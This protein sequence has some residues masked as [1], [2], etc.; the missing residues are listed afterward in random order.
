MAE[1]WATIAGLAITA[2][3]TAYSINAQNNAIDAANSA[4]PRPF[5][6]I[7]IGKT[8]ELAKAADVAGYQASD[9]EWLTRYQNSHLLKA[10]RDYNVSDASSNL[11]GATSPVVTNAM[12]KAGLAGDLGSNEFQKAQALGKPILSIEQRDRNFFRQLLA[13]NPQRSAGLT[14]GDVTK[15]A[16]QNTGA[17]GAYNSNIFGNKINQYNAQ[18][19]QGIQNQNA[20]VG[21]LASLAGLFSQNNRPN[22]SS[23]LEP[24][25]YGHSLG[26]A[27]G[28][29]GYG[30]G[31]FN[32]TGR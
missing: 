7:N 9:S 32:S 17:Q 6:P 22:Q 8:A 28:G 30:G 11:S 25:Y 10:G 19:A 26:G 15:L 12:D 13:E 1:V 18:I 31:S 20:A 23:Y 21:G 14:G 4:H 29:L 16:A 3:G 5:V 2:A 24:G 27:Y